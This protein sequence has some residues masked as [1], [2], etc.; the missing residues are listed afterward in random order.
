[1][2]A[3]I[4]VDSATMMNKGHEIIEAHHLFKQPEHRIEVLIH[5]QSVVHSMV[6]YLDGSVL[7]QLGSPDMRVPIAHALAWPSRMAAPVTRLDLAKI[8]A[9]TFEPPD[10]ERFPALKLARQALIAGG[11]APTILNAANEVA[12]AGFLAGA[13]G[14]LAIPEVVAETLARV[15]NRPLDSLETVDE[16]DRAAREVASRLVGHNA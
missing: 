10:V 6:A 1:M 15:P 8:G 7:A 16:V 2:G 11:A 4:S 13:T 14:F 12:V 3:K 5:P 9:L